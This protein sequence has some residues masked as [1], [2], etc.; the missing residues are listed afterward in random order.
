M[1]NKPGMVSVANMRC[2][3]TLIT[4]L[5]LSN[6]GN[7]KLFNNN[8]ICYSILPKYFQHKGH[9]KYEIILK[10]SNYSVNLLI[11]INF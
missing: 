3:Q 6:T 11:K 2:Q 7:G 10:L 4:D 9:I 1:L 8:V 5:Q